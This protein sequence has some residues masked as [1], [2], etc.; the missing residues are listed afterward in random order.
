MKKSATIASVLL[1]MAAITALSAQEA[2]EFP[3]PQKEHEWLKQFVGEWETSSEAAMAGPDGE[4]IECSGT[5]TS[6]MLGG[7]WVVNESTMNVP[8]M[9]MNAIQ[10]IGYDPEKKKYVGTW[11]DSAMNHLWHYE[12]TVDEGGTKLSLDAEGPNFMDAGKTAKFRDAYEF[13]SPD[14]IVVTSSMMGED[15]E[16]V[17]FMTGE[18]RRKQ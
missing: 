14:H 9:T 18:A 13:K 7:F 10:T 12:G 11:I 17:T 8:G 3:Q 5:M 15:G 16:W 1:S 4:K 6:R 2:P